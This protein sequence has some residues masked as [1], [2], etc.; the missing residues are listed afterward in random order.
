MKTI[1]VK[2]NN[3]SELNDFIKNLE[4]YADRTIKQAVV[5][6]RYLSDDNKNTLIGELKDA[7]SLD[8]FDLFIIGTAFD[9]DAIAPYKAVNK[10]STFVC[11]ATEI[12]CAKNFIV[13]DTKK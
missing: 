10:A 6:T 12:D 2:S 1:I 8:D 13:M 3:S 11:G 7:Q 4:H 5:C 9:D